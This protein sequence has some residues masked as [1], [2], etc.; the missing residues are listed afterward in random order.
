LKP[1]KTKTM[2]PPNPI[3]PLSV[4]RLAAADHK[5]PGWRKE[6]GRTF[7]VA[8]TAGR[9][10]WIASGSSVTRGNMNKRSTMNTYTG[11]STLSISLNT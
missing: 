3:P 6:I 2:N 5:A 8:I 9:M 1:G 4:V 7:R 11:T 10:A